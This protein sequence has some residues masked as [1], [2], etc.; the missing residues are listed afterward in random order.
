MRRG[1][2][3]QVMLCAT[4]TVVFGEEQVCTFHECMMETQQVLRGGWGE[5]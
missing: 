2:E 5:T 1:R 4:G 3:E